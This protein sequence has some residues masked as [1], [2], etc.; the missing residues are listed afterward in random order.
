MRITKIRP[1]TSQELTIPEPSI[2]GLRRIIGTEIRM[3]HP[4]P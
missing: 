3:H 1:G 2:S 4:T